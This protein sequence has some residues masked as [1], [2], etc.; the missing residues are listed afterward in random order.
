VPCRFSNEPQPITLAMLV[1]MS[2]GLFDV[3]K[4]ALHTA[5]L[6]FVAGFCARSRQIG[7]FPA[8]RLPLVII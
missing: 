5:L 7:T 6:A 8:T 4:Y 1:D 3:N 2:G